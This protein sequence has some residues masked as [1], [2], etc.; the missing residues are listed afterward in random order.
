M[1]KYRLPKWVR[2]ELRKHTRFQQQ[3]WLACAAIPRGRTQT[4]AW[5]ARRVGKPGAARAVGQALARNPFAP[6]VPC[7]RVVGRDGSLTGYSA[8]GGLAAKRRLLLKEG[9]LK[10]SA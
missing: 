10:P 1:A 8:S 3:V 7:H 2:Q 9:A 4:Y 5:I 6:W